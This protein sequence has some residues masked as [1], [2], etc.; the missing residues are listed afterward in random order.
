MDALKKAKEGYT[1]QFQLDFEQLFKVFLEE[2][3]KK[4]RGE[5][6]YVPEAK[7]K[8]Q[9]RNAA[10]ERRDIMIEY[11]RKVAGSE[12]LLF[13]INKPNN[14][15]IDKDDIANRVDKN[16]SPFGRQAAYQQQCIQSEAKSIK[17]VLAEEF[18]KLKFVK[19]YNHKE[20]YLQQE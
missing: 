8:L 13:N 9:K 6:P 7:P 5:K 12:P 20:L 15:K 1:D 3:Q 19:E 16:I 10:K 4:S 2:Q 14:V 11:G 17:K 18:R